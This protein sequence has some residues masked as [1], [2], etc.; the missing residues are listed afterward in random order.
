[1]TTRTQRHRWLHTK[2]ELRNRYATRLERAKADLIE[3][4]RG[5]KPKHAKRT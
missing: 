2:L 5:Y 4:E 1:M 3:K